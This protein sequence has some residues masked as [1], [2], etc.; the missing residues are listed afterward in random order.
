MRR[1]LKLNSFGMNMVDLKPG[2]NIP[3]HDE[4]GRDQEEVFIVWKGDATMVIDGIE[5]DA[6]EGSFVRIDPELKRTAVNKSAKL[7]R[8][9]IV[10]A[11]RSSGYQPMDWA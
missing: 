6:P 7:V 4:I 3:E 8:L 9:L 5:Y 10:S 1:S 2:E 11:P